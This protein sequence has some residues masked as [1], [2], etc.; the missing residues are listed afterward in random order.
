LQ[1]IDAEKSEKIMLSLRILATGK[2]LPSQLITAEDLDIQLSK[3]AGYT[4]KKSG[5]ATRHFADN[6]LSQS[7]LGASALQDAVNRA[8]ITV[9]SIDLLISACGVQEQALPS[10][11]CAIAAHAGL[12]D[13]TPAFD[14]N[15]SCLGFLMALNIAASLLNT[16]AYKR[17]AIVS[18]DLPSRGLNWDDPESSLIFGD[19]A[20]AVIVETGSTKQGVQ[21][22]SFKTFPVGRHF[23]EIRAGGT[24]RNPN[25]GVV[26]S[27]YLFSMNGKQVLKLAL[28][29]MPLFLADLLTQ[30]DISMQSV[31]LVV[32]HQ[33]SHLG[34]SHMSKRL[35]FNE[36]QI[37]NIYASH[38][39]QVAASMP[40]ALHEA[41][42]A[43][44]LAAGKRALLL[45]TAA[46]VSF[47]GMVLDL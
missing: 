46:G 43:G 13:G 31:D 40:S 16:Q 33:A 42:M 37:M 22:F 8:A 38:G 18:A 11:A 14:V 20:A 34:M 41:F 21:A 17:I 12:R 9:D 24:Q 19:G 7:A 3:P 23:C 2:T 1:K 30:S 36:N 25:N 45:G 10:T 5:V 35:G 39:N 47:G 28:Q 32:P 44:K 27:D 15:A 6:S 29:K 4:L 26:A